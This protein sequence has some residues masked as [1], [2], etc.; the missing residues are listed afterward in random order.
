[1]LRVTSSEFSKKKLAIT[2]DNDTHSSSIRL[3]LEL[4]LKQKTQQ[5]AEW[6]QDGPHQNVGSEG[7]KAFLIGIF[8]K[9]KTSSK[10][11]RT[12]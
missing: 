8:V 3:F 12:S 9:S 7:F 10:L 6:F 5:I 4:V 1:V 11:T 2:A